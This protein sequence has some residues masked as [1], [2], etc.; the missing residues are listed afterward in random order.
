MCRDTATPTKPNPD[1]L[2]FLLGKTLVGWE[3]IRDGLSFVEGLQKQ[4]THRHARIE[5]Y[6]YSES[7]NLK[8]TFRTVLE[9]DRYIQSRLRRLFLEKMGDSLKIGDIQRASDEVYT[10]F[11]KMNEVYGYVVV[12]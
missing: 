8:V 3:E 4:G 6:E 9:L 7:S 2:H 1:G 5:V 12:N 11:N 10:R